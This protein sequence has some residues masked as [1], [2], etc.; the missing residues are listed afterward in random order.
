MSDKKTFKIVIHDPNKVDINNDIMEEKSTM[1]EIEKKCNSST[2]A[3]QWLT[4]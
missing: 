1:L 3:K 2:E 4:D